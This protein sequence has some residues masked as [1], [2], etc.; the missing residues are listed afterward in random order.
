LFGCADF[1]ASLED[2]WCCVFGGGAGVPGLATCGGGEVHPGVFWWQRTVSMVIIVVNCCFHDNCLIMCLT[3]LTME[4][5]LWCH[6]GGVLLETAIRWRL[7]DPRWCR[8]CLFFVWGGHDGRFFHLSHLI[9]LVA[10]WKEGRW[11]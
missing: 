10:E 7:E 1:L 11:R 6:H 4:V 2:R 3:Q 9:S 5:C 8:W